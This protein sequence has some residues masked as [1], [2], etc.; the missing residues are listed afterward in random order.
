LENITKSPLLSGVKSAEQVELAHRERRERWALSK[1]DSFRLLL[2][3]MMMM[4]SSMNY[5][6]SLSKR[7]LDS[8]R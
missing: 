8:S 3:P 5:A 7:T 6:S 1:Q 2:Q 4:K